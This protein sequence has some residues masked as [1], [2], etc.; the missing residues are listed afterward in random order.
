MTSY[1]EGR[2][3]VGGEIDSIDFCG[4]AGGEEKQKL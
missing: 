3:T 4:G 1:S 2:I